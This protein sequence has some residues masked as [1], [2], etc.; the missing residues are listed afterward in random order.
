MDVG[1]RPSK[2]DVLHG[3]EGRDLVRFLGGR[4]LALALARPLGSR[5]LRCCLRLLLR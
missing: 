2:R 1:L 5:R 3:D 4:N